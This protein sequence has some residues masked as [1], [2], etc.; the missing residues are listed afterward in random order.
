M[1]RRLRVTAP[2][3]GN[4]ALYDWAR[5][6]TDALNGL[7][8]FSLI[9][10]SAGPNSSVTGDPGALAFDVGSSVTKLWLKTSG[11]TTTGW[12]ALSWI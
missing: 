4:G 9:S 3:P 12:S 7:P 6:V 11:S 1:S 8:N 2:P 10:T 5:Q